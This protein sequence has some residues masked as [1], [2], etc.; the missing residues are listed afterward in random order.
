[1]EHLHYTGAVTVTKLREY[2]KRN[3]ETGRSLTVR[4]TEA[5]QL[6]YALSPKL[7]GAAP[8]V[9]AVVGLICEAYEW[10]DA[11][12]SAGGKPYIQRSIRLAVVGTFD[13]EKA[14]LPKLP[15]AA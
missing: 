10:T 4:T 14:N 2:P 8:V 11:A 12:V 9:G 5:K 7:N 15:V 1:M 3:G 13:P 6:E